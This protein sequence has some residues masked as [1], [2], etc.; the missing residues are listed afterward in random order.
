[1]NGYT[2][3]IGRRCI[4]LSSS[5]KKTYYDI[6][7]VDRTATTKDI[8]N[9]YYMLSKKYHPDVTGATPGS[10]CSSKFVELSDAYDTLKDTEKRR[11][12]DAQ[13]SSRAF[14]SYAQDHAYSSYNRRRTYTDD[15]MMR[16]WKQY[17]DATQRNAKFDQEWPFGSN[18]YGGARRPGKT[19]FYRTGP[20]W[21]Y[22]KTTF[23]DKDGNQRTTFTYTDDLG[24]KRTVT[25]NSMAVSWDFLAKIFKLYMVAF[26]AVTLFQVGYYQFCTWQP[27]S[28]SHSFKWATISS[29]L[30]CR[31]PTRKSDRD[32]KLLES[33]KKK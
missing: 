24:R 22:E 29:V 32:E 18:R 19:F 33:N 31:W 13:I 27:S 7:G 17:Q 12:Y 3:I 25:R 30:P 8:K 10:S 14:S 26:F 1:M 16:I 28:P 11:I 4:S 23:T 20:G 2:T 15:E 5:W 21:S 9:A 6:L